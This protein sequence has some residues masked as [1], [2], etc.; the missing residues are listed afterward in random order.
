MILSPDLRDIERTAQSDAERKLARLLQAVES[1]EAVAFYSVKLRTAP[2]KQMAEADFVILW[3]GVAIIAEVKGGG[4]KKFGGAWYTIDR[5]G[6][7]H[8]LKL[9]PIDQARDAMFALRNILKEDGLGWF[10]SEA[11][12]VTPDIDHPPTD[13][14]WKATHWLAKE[15]MTVDALSSALDAV[16][17]SAPAAPRGAPTARVDELREDLF[18][19]FSRVPV[20]D[21]QRGAVIDEQNIA[22][23]DQARVLAGLAKNQRILVLGGAGTGKSVVLAEAAKQEAAAGRSVLVTF[24]SPGL[25]TFFEPR[26]AGRAIEVCEF[27]AIDL[28]SRFDVLLVDEAQ[29]LMYVD[30]MDVLDGVLA[31]GRERG[32]WRM[33]L[34]QNNQAHVDGRFDEDVFEIVR[35]EGIEYELSKNVR[36]TRA[37][38]HMVQE[39]LGADVGDPGIVNGERIQWETVPEGESRAQAV[40]IAKSFKRDG[41]KAADIWLLPASAAE[42]LD[43]VVD[44]IRVLSPRVAK[45]LEAEH[46]IVCELPTEYSD[47]AL[48]ALYVAVTRA[49]VTLRVV[50]TDADRRRLQMVLHRAGAKA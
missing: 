6:D 1:A 22:T 50:C 4:V 35:T 16:A 2:G 48:A 21:A 18:G 32:R 13:V 34:D 45:G 28:N 24:R 42:S 43:E 25:R 49:R 37:I 29:D 12:A 14:A 19:E 31:G 20:I 44:G 5:N 36:N 10:P 15:S 26:L 47:A 46:V 33:F 7:N 27:D 39:Y 9:S 17:R 41:V 38:V 30:A 3:K 11:I 40:R 23:A 8:K